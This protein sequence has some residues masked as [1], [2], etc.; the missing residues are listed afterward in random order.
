MR[1]KS[2][3]LNSHSNKMSNA[4]SNGKNDRWTLQNH[5]I[6]RLSKETRTTKPICANQFFSEEKKLSADLRVVYIASL[7]EQNLDIWVFRIL[8]WNLVRQKFVL[9]Y[10]IFSKFFIFT[11]F[12]E[13]WNSHRD[14]KLSNFSKNETGFSETKLKARSAKNLNSR[15]WHE[16]SLRALSFAPLSHF[17]K[18]WEIPVIQ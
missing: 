7:T 3:Q 6:S 11:I 4:I 14:R 9:F 17:S 5:E 1:S 8:V 16:A 15:I 10:V 2:R 18:A 13:N 12:G